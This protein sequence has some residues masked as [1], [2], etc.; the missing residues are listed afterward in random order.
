MERQTL[1]IALLTALGLIGCTKPSPPTVA[2]PQ[3]TNGSEPTVTVKPSE[4]KPQPIKPAVSLPVQPKPQTDEALRAIAA[5]LVLPAGEGSWRINES[6]ALELERLGSDAPAK[7]LGLLTDPQLE[8][9]RGAAFHLLSSFDPS[10]KDQVAAFSGLL[11]DQDA[12]IRGLGLTA[13]KQMHADDVSAAQPQLIALL[14]P[15]QETKPEN[16]ATVARFAGSLSHRGGPFA[17]ALSTAAVND[18]DE[19]VRS[20]AIFALTQVA[21]PEAYL[22]TLTKVLH[23]PKPNVRLVAA[24]RLRALGL[25]AHPAVDELGKA[26]AD[27]DDRVRTAA[28]EALTRIGIL[29]IPTLSEQLGS[30]DV[31]ARKLALACL[32]GLGPAAKSELPKIEKLQQDPDKDVREAANI[33]VERLK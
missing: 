31:N 12:T 3:P 14:D 20:A 18:P 1:L 30:K 5:K 15:T 6:S 32:A 4:Q 11:K 26:L 25:Q 23:D 29:A 24:G 21:K 28:A 16:R 22:S 2:P 8:V 13:V 19:R 33:L 10:A 7:L 17:A 27:E 9:R